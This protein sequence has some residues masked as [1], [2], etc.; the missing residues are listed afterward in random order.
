VNYL[1][2]SRK[3]QYSSSASDEGHKNHIEQFATN[4]RAR[5]VNF[6]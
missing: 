3:T 2:P 1:R 4:W 5:R 6:Q